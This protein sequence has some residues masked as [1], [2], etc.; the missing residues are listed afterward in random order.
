MRAHE[1][2]DRSTGGML[3][4]GSV[5]EADG[6][7]EV[8]VSRHPGSKTGQIVIGSTGWQSHP[9]LRGDSLRLLPQTDSDEAVS[10]TRLG[11]A[12]RTAYAGIRNVARPRA[13]ETVVVTAATSPLGIWAGQF[14]RLDGTWSVAIVSSEEE[15]KYAVQTLGFQTAVNRAASDLESRLSEVCVDGIDVCVETI[16]G[17]L[18]RE[19]RPLMNEG[20]RIVLT[21]TWAQYEHPLSG[22]SEYGS[23]PTIEA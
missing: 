4:P 2:V 12:A 21:G 8:L 18:W 23:L 20:G 5:I 22:A 1:G 19:I 14:A 6:T 16:G 13:G 10:L 11:T 7:A 3:R 9:R 15:C 17:A